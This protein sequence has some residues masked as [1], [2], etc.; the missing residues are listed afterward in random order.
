MLIAAEMH[1]FKATKSKYQLY[2]N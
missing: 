1:C 2:N